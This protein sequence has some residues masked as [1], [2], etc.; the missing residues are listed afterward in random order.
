[1]SDSTSRPGSDEAWEELLR[2]LRNQSK[3]QPPPF[4]YARVQARLAAE[5]APASWLP[6]WARRP[7]YAALL[8]ALVLAVSGDGAALRPAK[9]ASQP[10]QPAL[11]FSH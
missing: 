1:M 5:P 3:A 7:A 9:L 6:G 11:L 4:F 2:Q 8:G 10:S